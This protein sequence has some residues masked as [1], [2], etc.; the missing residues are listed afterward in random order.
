MK[1]PLCGYVEDVDSLI[2]GGRGWITCPRC[3]GKGLTNE[4]WFC[5]LPTEEKAKWLAE[6]MN[7]SYCPKQEPC[8]TANDCKKLF[9]EWLKEKH[10]E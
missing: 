6:H 4:E 7:C 2:D 1:C 5:Q 3:K 9:I 10:T 8:F